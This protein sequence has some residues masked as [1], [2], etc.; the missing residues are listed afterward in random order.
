MNPHSHF[1]FISP[2]PMYNIFSMR[3]KYSDRKNGIIRYIRHLNS[4]K[5]FDFLFFAG[6][7]VCS[8]QTLQCNRMQNWTNIERFCG[9]TKWRTI[10]MMLFAFHGM[11]FPQNF[12]NWKKLPK[13]IW[14][15]AQ[16]LLMFFQAYLLFLCYFCFF[17]WKCWAQCCFFGRK[18]CLHNLIS[19]EQQIMQLSVRE[20]LLLFAFEIRATHFYFYGNVLWVRLECFIQTFE[21]SFAKNYWDLITKQ[22]I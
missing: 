5:R 19:L 14:K 21:N 22:R 8:P 13:T 9:K 6:S 17:W 1:L 12:F 11:C 2:H 16:Q 4:V 15:C 3:L 10:Y 20:V 7:L 18:P